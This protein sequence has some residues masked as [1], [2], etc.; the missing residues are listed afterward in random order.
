MTER[1][2]ISWLLLLLSGL[3]LAVLLSLGTWQV[4][5]LHWKEALLAEIDERIHQ[6][7]M[8]LDAL[9]S[10]LRS[11]EDID[12]VPVVA[13]GQFDHGKEQ[14]FFATH[15][16]ESGYFVYTPLNIANRRETVFVNRGFV[17]FD[18]KDAAARADGQV[19]GAVTITGLARN[20]LKAKPSFLV[21]DNDP[22]KNIFYW[23][24]LDAM[25]KNAGLD[26]ASVLPLFV[27]ANDAPNAG[28]LPQGSVTLIDL[29]NNHLQY[30]ITWY[31]LAAAL[32]GVVAVY[33]FRRRADGEP[34]AS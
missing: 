6:A 33:M 14:F 25:A 21:P 3:A 8:P 19:Q 5:R 22:A 34:A 4:K 32:A 18:R 7:P 23:K 11:G 17:P 30:A 2:R 26:P 29:P 12:Y 9:L 28:G 31:G 16:G 24:D 15:K 20:R 1:R 13:E 10:R 27:D